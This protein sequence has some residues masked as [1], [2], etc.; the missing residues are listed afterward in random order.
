M[1]I[2]RLTAEPLAI[3]RWMRQRMRGA[4]AM[5]RARAPSEWAAAS[6]FSARVGGPRA[7]SAAMRPRYPRSGAGK[8]GAMRR[9][10]STC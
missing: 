4:L 3:A 9:D 10:I 5:A 7:A 8:R 1:Q 2:M 6:P